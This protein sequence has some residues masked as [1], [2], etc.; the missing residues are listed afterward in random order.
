VVAANPGNVMALNNLA[1]VLASNGR[2]DA[3]AYAKQAE[4]L[5][6]D[7]AAILDTLAFTLVAGKQF[8]EALAVQSRAVSLEPKD[9]RLRLNL[10]DIALKSGDKALAR[11]ELQRL[12]EL[13][14]AF[15]NQ[16]E[17]ARLLQAL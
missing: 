8:S 10:A 15:P 12:K 7:S 13:G 9:N 16:A 11:Q 6:P 5:A 3:L 1:W 14:S 17:V 4:A 2:P